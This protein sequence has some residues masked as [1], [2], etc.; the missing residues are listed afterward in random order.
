[1]SAHDETQRI[2]TTAPGPSAPPDAPT[3]AVRAP[4]PLDL[5]AD[6]AGSDT[7]GVLSLDELFGRT[8][9]DSDTP[10]QPP[11]AA[12]TSADAPTWTAM[13]VVSVRSEPS[14][15][16]TAA[17]SPAPTPAQRSGP[18]LA[19]QLLDDAAVAWNRAINRSGTW[20]RAG[21]NA[22]MITTALAA[23]VLILVVA[24]FSH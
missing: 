2:R 17:P 21:D 9:E 12:T 5:A 18:R 1:M 11:A 13:P 7:T 16:G 23:I 24:T 10:Q 20:L 6:T 22:L 19:E 8:G 3:T 4:G 15:A 14:A